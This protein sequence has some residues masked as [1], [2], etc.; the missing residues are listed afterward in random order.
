[1]KRKLKVIILLFLLL[2]QISAFSS[3]TET[4]S[5][6]RFKSFSTHEGLSQ[7]SV[8]AITQD[9]QGFIWIGT[10]DGLNRFDGYNFVTFK[11]QA[12][13]PKSISNNEVIFLSGDSLGN[14]FIGTRGGGLNYFIKDEN[15]FMHYDGLKTMDGTVNC[16]LQNADGTIWV[17]TS[18]GLYKGIPD[19]TKAFN[20]RFTNF[21]KKSVYLNSK[22]SLLP[23]DRS[24]ISVVTL[25]KLNNDALLIGTYK[26]FFLFREKDL[27]FN[28]IDLGTLNKAKVNSMVW[29]H[30]NF[31]WVATS[32]GLVKLKVGK[33]KVVS[34]YL[35]NNE[36]PIWKKL[37]AGWVE[38]LIC[39]FGGNLWIATRGA[40]V[41]IVDENGKLSDYVNDNSSSDRI[42][43]NIINS[44]MIDRTGIL[45]MGTESRG[46]ITL[47]LNRKKFNHLENK[48]KTGKNLTSNLVTAI[49]G[50]DNE[51]WVGTAYNGLDYLKFNNDR[52]ISTSHF[53]QIP[54]GGGLSSSEIIS[55]LLDNNNTLWIGTASN[56]LVAY[57]K[58]SGFESYYTGGFAFALHQDHEGSIWIGTWG[59]GLGM[60]EDNGNNIQFFANQPNDSRTL[61]GD[62]I[63]SIFD[64][65]R[66]NL[67]VGT[68]G[69]GL[70][71]IPLKLIKQGYN[72]FVSFEKNSSILHNDV[73]CIFQDSD[74]MIWIG[75]GGGLNRL[76]LNSSSSTI[77]ELY[78][79]RVKFDA[80]TEKDGLPANLIYSICEDQEG[81][82]WF[83]TTKGLAKY[84]K[85]TKIF[86]NKNI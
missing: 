72:N 68:K 15:R 42:G 13:D 76:N 50:K 78:K 52:T 59:K 47:D 73:Y 1:M 69:R 46:V 4:Y 41:I 14:I 49:T 54:C 64:D 24:V 58:K 65:N 21:S 12:N 31:L 53:N 20:Y 75:T 61:S 36:N 23:Y 39:D 27:S 86:K 35:F 44:L 8:L 71:V 22:E 45:W 67:W 26:G 28:Q 82:L 5:N 56:N 70:N 7:S 55:L 30:S 74:D 85:K 32:E 40:G 11:N 9:A 19:S 25:K 63:L 33:E 60:M 37:N 83:S 84:N 51:I 3:E 66:G 80:F 62:V 34:S 57:Q 16:V 79:G 2:T 48:T 18:E 38:N 77:A 17:G 6:L 81:N 43:D 29:D 10:K